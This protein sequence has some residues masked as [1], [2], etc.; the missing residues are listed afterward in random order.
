MANQRPRT[1]MVE[2]DPLRIPDISL[3]ASRFVGM[4]VAAGM[5]P[6]L[7]RFALFPYDYPGELCRN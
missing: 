1:P 2:H 4:D 3:S 5:T 7:P 6:L